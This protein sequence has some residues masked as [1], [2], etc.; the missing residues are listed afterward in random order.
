MYVRKKKMTIKEY[1]QKL[2]EIESTLIDKRYLSWLWIIIPM[3]L[4]SFI[5]IYG[6]LGSI[7][8]IAAWLYVSIINT[9]KIN[10]L[11]RMTLIASTPE[12]QEI[13]DV[14]DGKIPYI[15]A[16]ELAK[17]ATEMDN[18]LIDLYESKKISGYEKWLIFRPYAIHLKKGVDYKRDYLEPDVYLNKVP[19]TVPTW[20]MRLTPNVLD[21]PHIKI[22][23]ARTDMISRGVATS[24]EMAQFVDRTK[25]DRETGVVSENYKDEI[26][27]I[28]KKIKIRE[29]KIRNDESLSMEDRMKPLDYDFNIR[30][31][32]AKERRA[33]TARF[34]ERESDK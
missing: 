1:Y 32:E 13:L 22:Y 15:E 4:A 19:L 30:K 8:I 12:I 29:E 23:C 25:K 34:L 20:E 3:C 28:S 7:F 33:K 14:T 9:K 27:E 11:R 31:I 26:K 5:T 2:N 17:Q 21:E 18:I 24:E 6:I 16:T 10:A